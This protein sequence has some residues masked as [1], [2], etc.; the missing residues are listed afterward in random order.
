MARGGEV[1]ICQRRERG[2]QKNCTYNCFVP[3][4][5]ENTDRIWDKWAGSIFLYIDMYIL[6]LR[7]ALMLW[8]LMQA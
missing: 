1:P 4:G 2:A 8:N 7:F 6:Y 5:W 3:A